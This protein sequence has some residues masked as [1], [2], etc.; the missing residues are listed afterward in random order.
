MSR[1]EDPTERA[2]ASPQEPAETR[3][4][5]RS[6][7]GASLLDAEVEAPINAAVQDLDF[8]DTQETEGG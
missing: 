4:E 5:V 7:K 6:G 8:D 3:D 1:P 2:D